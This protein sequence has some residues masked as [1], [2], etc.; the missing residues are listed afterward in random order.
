LHCPVCRQ[1]QR[2][3]HKAQRE[4]EP[5]QTSPSQIGEDPNE[6]PAIIEAVEAAMEEGRCGSSATND[7]APPVDVPLPGATPSTAED[8]Q[9]ALG[10]SGTVFVSA[11]VAPEP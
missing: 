6:E 9:V 2:K 10:T 3:G 11:A 1:K 4:E 8:S 7:Q 5:E